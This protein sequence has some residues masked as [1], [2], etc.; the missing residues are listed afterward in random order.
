M[1]GTG[2]YCSPADPSP[3][4]RLPPPHHL[5]LLGGLLA[6]PCS[7]GREDGADGEEEA[8]RATW[9]VQVQEDSKNRV[10][11]SHKVRYQ[12]G[13][14]V[15]AIAPWTTLD[16]YYPPCTLHAPVD[17]VVHPAYTVK[18]Q[19]RPVFINGWMLNA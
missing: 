18:F 9:Q 4:S 15:V 12:F 7:T 5:C 2:W 17:Y 10:E 11:E 3:F 16:P 1:S 19:R 6:L 14:Y 13:Q 8:R